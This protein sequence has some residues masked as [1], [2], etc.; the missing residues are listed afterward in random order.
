MRKIDSQFEN[1]LD[2][3]L[4]SYCEPVSI[5]L[6]ANTNIT[7]NIIT[8]I[9]LFFGMLSIYNLINK[10]YLYSFIF[11]WICYYL[12]CLDGYFA[13][14]YDM[15]TEFGGYYDFTRDIIVNLVLVI[16]IFLQLKTNKSKIF[17]AIIML[18]GY[19]LMLIHLGCQERIY[20]DNDSVIGI[21]KQLCSDNSYIN[22]TK[23][24]G[25]GTMISI[26]SLFILFHNNIKI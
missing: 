6:R 12:D 15:V 18:I 1:P 21:L 4:I 13:R 16:I 25:C 7:P 14:K 19:Y 11:Y 9:G 10:N 2:N 22:N 8:T 17:F 3:I 24:F 26:T 20:N 23:F 5:W